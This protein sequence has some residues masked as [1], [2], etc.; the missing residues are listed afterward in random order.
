MNQEI[1][2]TVTALVILAY[3]IGEIV[4]GI[5]LLSQHATFMEQNLKRWDE[6]RKAK[7]KNL[8]EVVK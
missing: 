3:K 6:E 7:K 1:I 4:G 2:I 5:K 8:K